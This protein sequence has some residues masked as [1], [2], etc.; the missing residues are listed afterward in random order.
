MITVLDVFMLTWMEHP[1]CAL[2]FGAS[3]VCPSLRVRLHSLD[4]VSRY[5]FQ[6]CSSSFCRTST[7]YLDWI[8][9]YTLYAC[10][11]FFSL[12]VLYFQISFIIHFHLLSI[13]QL[14]MFVIQ[15]S[16][17]PMLHLIFQFLSLSKPPHS[18]FPYLLCYRS[19]AIF[20][21]YVVI[22]ASLSLLIR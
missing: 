1:S 9:P 11:T 16:D 2:L 8:F 6:N 17:I 7:C 10:L 22:C 13:Y 14:Y 19:N 12:E 5:L 4:L 15:P 3:F 20:R 21:S 18:R